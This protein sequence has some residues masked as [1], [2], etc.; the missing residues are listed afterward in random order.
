MHSS[1]RPKKKEEEKKKTLGWLHHLQQERGQKH[2]IIKHNNNKIQVHIINAKIL[3]Q[4]QQHQPGG[5][6]IK[7]PCNNKIPIRLVQIL[8]AFISKKNPKN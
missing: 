6:Y 8:M 3:N 4:D 7:P 2:W 5:L 1:F